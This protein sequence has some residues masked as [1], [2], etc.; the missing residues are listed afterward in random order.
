MPQSKNK[1]VCRGVVAHALSLGSVLFGT[2][3]VLSGHYNPLLIG[4][5]LASCAVVVFI[6]HRMDVIDH[7][8][9]P[10]HLTWRALLYWPWL[11]VEIV[12]ANFD[13]ARRILPGGPAI[14]PTML[15][16]RATQAND[17]G[18]V[19]FA[20][21]ITLTPG[22]VTMDIDDGEFW[23]HAVSDKVARDLQAGDMERRVAR[24]FLE[25]DYRPRESARESDG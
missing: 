14:S 24:V 20:N 5:G 15:R 16:V 4:L 2:W 19:I 7:E 6:T 12:K 9:H 25:G 8:G 11:V 21:S 3:L 23:V 1:L 22:T 10:I 17:L 13:V 18:R